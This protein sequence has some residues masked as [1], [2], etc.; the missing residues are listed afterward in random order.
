MRLSLFSTGGGAASCPGPG[1]GNTAP[2]HAK[3]LA[4]IAYR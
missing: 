2:A 1:G 4:S 3:M